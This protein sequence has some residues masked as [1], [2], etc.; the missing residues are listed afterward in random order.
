MVKTCGME[1]TP[2]AV[3]EGKKRVKGFATKAEAKEYADKQNKKQGLSENILKEGIK[4]LIK[5]V[6]FENTEEGVYEM[7]GSKEDS[8]YKSELA[9]YLDDNGIFGFT[10]KIHSI[11]TGPDEAENADELVRFLEDNQIYGYGRGIEAIYADY[12][13]DQHYMNQPDE[14]E[15]DIPHPIGYKGYESPSDRMYNSDAWV[16]AQR[17]MME[18]IDTEADKNMVRKLMAMYET[19]PAKFK[20]LHKQAKVQASTTQ[21]I[22]HK[23]LLSLID[24]AKA[25]ALQKATPEIPGFKGT[26]DALDDLFESDKFYAPTYITQKYGAAK[27]KE[28][29]ANIEDEGANTW[30]LFTSLETPKEVDDFIGGFTMD[31]SVSLKDIL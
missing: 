18:G 10:S 5:K 2:W 11:M 19:D 4:N 17:D 9:D 25:G 29:E 3:W 13:Y 23:H 1:G 15:D 7:H 28:I 30:D 21:D 16:Q 22:K 31:E 24:R 6:L 26:R 8:Y 12:P 27:A 14:D 20:R